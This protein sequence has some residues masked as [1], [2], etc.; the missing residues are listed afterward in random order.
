M[1]PAPRTEGQPHCNDSS[2]NTDLATQKPV[3][4][5]PDRAFTRNQFTRNQ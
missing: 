2:L 4:D 5:Q 3:G 1:D